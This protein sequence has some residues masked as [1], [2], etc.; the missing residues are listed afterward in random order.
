MSNH[1]QDP[2][3]ALRQKVR[4]V[5]DKRP[6]ERSSDSSD[7]IRSLDTAALSDQGRHTPT[8]RM[9]SDAIRQALFMLPVAALIVDDQ[10]KVR[11]A[12][13]AAHQLITRTT[14]STSRPDVSGEPYVLQHFLVV[15]DIE[16]LRGMVRQSILSK[17]SLDARI[18]GKRGHTE[19][20]A[21]HAQITHLSGEA[22]ASLALVVL[23]KLDAEKTSTLETAEP[24]A[25]ALLAGSTDYVFATD[26]GGRVIYANPA[27]LS[28]IDKPASEVIGRRL[29]YLLPLRNAIEHVQAENQIQ[30]T[31]ES[32]RM[33]EAVYLRNGTFEL[34]TH[35]FP[36]LDESSR[37]YGIGSISRDMTGPNESLRLQKLS[38]AIFLNTREAIVLTDAQGR[39]TRVNPG[40]ERITGFSEAAVLGKKLSLVHSGHQD[41]RQYEEIW[42]NILENGHW[43]GELV[44]RK[45]DGTEFVVWSTISAMFK[46]D[47]HLLG[48]LAVQ[49]DITDLRQANEKIRLLANTDTL[50][51]LP[52]RK[53]FLE[54]LDDEIGKAGTHHPSFA[55][56]FLDLDHFKEV[57]DSLGHHMGDHLLV[58]IAHRLGEATRTSDIVARLGGDEFTILLPATS[59]DEAIVIAH[60]ILQHVHYPLLL[61]SFINYR[62]QASI[63]IAMFPED[64]D[65]G[66]EL[67]KHADQAMYAAK[68]KGRNQARAYSA[69][70]EQANQRTF[71]LR[72]E[73]ADA[74]MNNELRVFLQPVFDL[75]TLDVIGA[76]AL[77]RWQHP[78]MGLLSPGEFLPVAQASKMMGAIDHWVLDAT[79]RQVSA[80]H[81]QGRWKPDWRVSIN[82]NTDDIRHKDWASELARMLKKLNLPAQAVGIELTEE[83]WTEPVPVVLKNLR[84]IQQMGLTLYIDDFGTGYSSLAYLKELP[85]S[86]IKIDQH[87][88]AQLDSA[89]EDS[90]LVEAIIALGKKLQYQ[91]IAEGVETE[92]QRKV[93]LAKGCTAAQGYLLSPPLSAKCFEER[94]LPE[95][96]PT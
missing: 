18:K 61:D 12:N 52:N 40:W 23:T 11:F 51:G 21:C 81:A 50:T 46:E 28:V 75:E 63:G 17:K 91:L 14:D 54:Q 53:K 78:S 7:L 79:L 41:S 5:V 94:F 76:E 47:G 82:Q 10:L 59:R 42:R 96:S 32:M 45:S 2:I 25:P 90:T 65:S 73:L 95:P 55:L 33:S 8:E 56:L 39:I 57:N 36:L 49:T 31:Q 30:A 85:A 92:A 88:V 9:I 43:S 62:P 6:A 1:P 71:T 72:R 3:E 15:D 38:E 44:N 67:L 70:L 69:D 58:Q 83:L 80:W 89:N 84:T 77:V 86:V 68:H 29:E 64:G 60:Q 24:I 87:F 48:Y 27:Y 93:L 34:D 13:L 4:N 35:K 74:L 37:L 22:G 20:I 16:L 19:I 66:Q 26:P